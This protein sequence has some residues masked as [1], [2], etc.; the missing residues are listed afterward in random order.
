VHH[1]FHFYDICRNSG[2]QSSYKLFV[3]D[4]REIVR[5]VS[6]YESS[7]R[8]ERC[9]LEPRASLDFIGLDRISGVL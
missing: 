5:L 9:I 1:S 7:I 2:I 6:V 4:F 8:I 3:K